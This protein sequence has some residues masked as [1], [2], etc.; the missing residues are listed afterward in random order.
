M[1]PADSAENL[2][3]KKNSKSPQGVLEMSIIVPG[4]EKV[5]L[6][7]D[8]N[9]INVK[10][11]EHFL[12][13]EGYRTISAY[14]GQEARSLARERRP[15]LILLDIMM[16]GE[17][18]FD[19]CILLKRDQETREIPIIFLSGMNDI[20]SQEKGRQ[21]GAVD[22]IT[23]PFK[24]E[25]VLR[26]TH[27]HLARPKPAIVIPDEKEVRLRYFQNAHQAM[28]IQPKD[29]PRAQFGV[30]YLPIVP[31]GNDLY[32]VIPVEEN[33]WVYFVADVSRHDLDGSFFSLALK[34]LINR[35]AKPGHSPVE[36]MQQVHQLLRPH[37]RENEFF[38]AA[39]LWVDR[40]RSRMVLV[41]AGRLPVIYQQAHHGAS[42]LG[43]KGEYI[44]T[45]E[46]PDFDVIEQAISPKDRIYL[47]TDGLMESL[48]ITRKPSAELMRKLLQ[49]CTDAECLPIEMA[50]SEINTTFK[51]TAPP[52]QDDVLLL[53]VEI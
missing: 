27:R 17:N 24:E 39:Y 37:L 40:T 42:L 51:L 34:A 29:L 33:S 4:E 52:S 19:T 30:S 6:I 12:N 11:L 53:G 50:P 15:D 48:D 23:K 26:R 22:Y 41:N 7:V 32:D 2:Q 25:E 3:G 13:S 36:L 10:L 44:S 8:D 5:I 38:S 21:L 16:P 47:F 45:S 28:L 31:A 43:G 9:P 18:G 20:N 35:K 46:E 1:T 14:N 49:C